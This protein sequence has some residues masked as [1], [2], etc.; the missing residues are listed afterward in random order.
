M[1][2]TPSLQLV[3]AMGF[4]QM[5]ASQPLTSDFFQFF[6]IISVTDFVQYWFPLAV[7][8]DSL[9]VEVSHLPP[10]RSEDELD[11]RFVYAPLCDRPAASVH[12]R[13]DVLHGVLGAG[14]L[15]VHF[16]RLSVLGVRA[17]KRA[18]PFRVAAVHSVHSEISSQASLR[19][20]RVNQHQLRRPLPDS[21]PTVRHVPHAGRRMAGRVRNQRPPS[22]AR[23][24][25]AVQVPVSE[26][27]RCSADG[28]RR[29]FVVFQ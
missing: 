25:L 24:L 22:A 5:V 14:A 8:R 1:S 28:V 12:D 17:F 20:E 29:R 3:Q 18:I 26:S 6:E 2:L 19:R 15:S 16:L 13:A 7:L 4:R 27:G 10:F 11:C 23:I 21:R 9:A